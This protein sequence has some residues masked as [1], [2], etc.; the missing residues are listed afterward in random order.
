M[1]IK[2]V[3]NTGY[4]G[5]AGC[6]HEFEYSIEEFGYDEDSWGQLS[7]DQIN[8]ILDDV[9]DTELSIKIEVNAWIEED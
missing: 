7:E 4:T 8:E 9:C 1:K 2:G 5:Y 6:S 3:I